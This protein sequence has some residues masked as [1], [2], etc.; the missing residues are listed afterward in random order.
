M[1]ILKIEI[2][3]LYVRMNHVQNNWSNE[4]ISGSQSEG[5]NASVLTSQQSYIDNSLNITS[6]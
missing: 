5:I 2:V 4:V 3:Q 6:Q 1:T